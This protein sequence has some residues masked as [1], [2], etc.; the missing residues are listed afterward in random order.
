MLEP[1]KGINPGK[2]LCM[3][4]KLIL[5]MLL[6]PVFACAEEVRI[7]GRVFS[8][9]GPLPGARVR[10]CGSFE[11][12][13]ANTSCVTSAPT[14]AEG[15]YRLKVAPGAHYFAASGS[16]GGREYYA[17]HG[18][19]PV[20]TDSDNLWVSF[21][22]NEVKP[23]GYTEGRAVLRGTVTYK[24]RPVP[25]A[26]VAL[27]S[28]Q[29]KSFKGIGI[30]TESVNGDGTFDLSVPFGKYVVIAKKLEG[31]SG[32]R[33]LKKGDLFCYSPHNPVELKPDQAV[34]NI[35]VPCYPKDDRGSF[36]TAPVIKGD[37][38]VSVAERSSRTTAGI[39]GRVT[40][41]TG[42]PVAGLFVMAYPSREPIFQ[43]YQVSH[44]TEHNGETDHDG[45]Y[46]IPLDESGEYNLVA[47]D[48]LGD[49][50]HQG[51]TYGLYQGN[52][53]HVVA[54]TKGKLVDGVNLTV[55]RVTVEKPVAAM[56]T[57][58]PHADAVPAKTGN[59]GTTT[60]LSDGVIERDTTWSGTVVIRG[61]I[62]VKRGVTLTI[63]PGTVV[64]FVRLDRD[65]NDIGDG[66]I[67][68]EGRLVARGTREKRIVFTSA[69]Q[70]PA[71]NDWSYLQ[72]L[73]S[74]AD[75]VLQYCRFEYGFVG[76]QIHYSTVSISD[77]TFSNNNRGLHF[78]TAS[79]TADHNSFVNNRIGIRFMRFEGKTLL[80]NNVIRDNDTGVLF[81]RQHVNAVDFE[82]LR[83]GDQQPRF[84][85][86]DIVGNHKYNFSLGDGQDQDVA[87]PGNWWGSVDPSAISDLIYDRDDDDALSRV[88]FTPYLTAPSPGAGVRQ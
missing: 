59:N 19:N 65:R 16:I 20:K 73:G 7:E 77:S 33:P 58:L 88:N 87:I 52:P 5:L 44:G 23:L 63:L 3:L 35:E 57:D 41:G 69:E 2:G 25:G 64:K 26:Y 39:R 28:P 30:R 80:S 4:Q 53:R 83:K 38:Y 86:N 24:G 62:S 46:F 76:V 45:V 10:A 13:Q 37:G 48:A 72:F 75:N 14:D 12:L 85:A 55:G 6:F 60:T 22:A 18:S 47:R 66:E 1:N 67:L 78:N 70:N 49:G 51:E 32:N 40:D 81:V 11:E 27:Y 43:M 82:K 17:Y 36:V 34:Q 68:V 29:D 84:V 54:Y 15:R 31:G 61:V 50:P 79:L 9:A 56:P 74:D 71:I 8:D 42:K 21:M